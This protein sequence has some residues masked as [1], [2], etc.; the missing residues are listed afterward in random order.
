MLDSLKITECPRAFAT[1][2]ER[3]DA[4]CDLLATIVGQNGITVVVSERKIVIDGSGAGG[5]SGD[6]TALTARV[7]ALETLTSGMSRQNVLYCS[8]GS[9]TTITILRT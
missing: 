4:L 1:F 6:L 9:N 7:A 2:A 3:H 5:G 8:A